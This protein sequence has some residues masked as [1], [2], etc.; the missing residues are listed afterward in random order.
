MILVTRVENPF[1]KSMVCLPLTTTLPQV[2]PSHEYRDAATRTEPLS[3]S[4][5]MAGGD[6]SRGMNLVLGKVTSPL[7]AKIVYWSLSQ[8][9]GEE[10]NG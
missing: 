5:G 8:V 7:P 9:L 3:F 1:L 10:K 2:T 6:T 4:T